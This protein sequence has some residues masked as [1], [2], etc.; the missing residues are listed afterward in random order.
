[1]GRFEHDH[2]I[3]QH[4]MTL[5]GLLGGSFNPA[6]GAHRSIS[7]FAID[8][9]QLDDM[10]WLVSPGNPLKSDKDMA[11]LSARLLSAQLQSHNSRI[12]ASAIESSLNT[13][14]TVDTLR[15][16][17]RKYPKRRFVW[18]MGADNLA[19]FHR[20]HKWREIAKIMPIAVIERPRYNDHARFGKAMHYLRQYRRPI[21]QKCSLARYKAPALLFLRFRPDYRSATKIRLANPNW[22]ERYDG[23]IAKDALTHILY[24]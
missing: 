18:I 12:T 1:M 20:W 11:P 6:H 14:F 2:Y 4:H 23:R 15:K 17:Q 24:V 21:D 16:L 8:R 7:L 22:F 3:V 5:T 9:L 19:Q 10:W 13:R